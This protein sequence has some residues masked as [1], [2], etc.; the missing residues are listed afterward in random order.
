MSEALEHPGRLG[1]WSSVD[2]FSSTEAVE[3]AQQIETWGYSTLWIPEAVGRDPFPMIGFLAA[4]TEKL[5]FATGIANIY[6]RDAILA[7]AIKQTCA[8]MLP[9]RFILGLGVSH[10][11]LVS[12]LRGHEW[13][14]PVKKMREYLEA[15]E[16]GLYMGP[17]PEH[18]APIVIAALRPRML[19]L[20]KEAARGA[21]PYLVTPEHTRRAREILG[22]GPW[23]C[24]EQKVILESDAATAR[25][26]ARENLKVYLR[27]PNY[28][29]SLLEL[30]FSEADF[31]ESE[32]SDGLVDAL[33]A[34]GD[35]DALRARV[36]EHWDAG[37]DHVCI[38]AFRTDG[39]QGPD[40]KALKLL[41]PAS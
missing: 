34:W 22:E 15:I 40:M 27:A 11:H 20:A 21:H 37:A 28:K 14:P 24:P 16:A 8:E 10:P 17:A 39:K 12:R 32:A 18:E 6:A 29:N 1:V 13:L 41:A 23:L 35:E 2:S 33:V 9:G 38:Q 7:K 4:Q 30:G 5:I 36:Q 3:F 26:I 31:A 19:K 25:R